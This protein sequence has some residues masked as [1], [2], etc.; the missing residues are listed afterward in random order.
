IYENDSIEEARGK[1]QDF[2][3]ALLDQ[4]EVADTVRYL[5]LILGLGADAVTDEQIHLLFAA[6]RVVELIAERGPLVLVF[7]DVHWADDPLLELIDYL[8]AH[9]HDHPVLFLALARPEFLESRT[10]FGSGMV[11]HTMLHLEPLTPGESAR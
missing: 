1:L 5:S 2:A 3:E 4:A 8:V 6:R 11:G 10:G 9:V 7:E